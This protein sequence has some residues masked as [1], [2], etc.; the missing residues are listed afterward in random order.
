MPEKYQKRIFE[1]GPEKTTNQLCN[2]IYHRNLVCTKAK[3][4]EQIWRYS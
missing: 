1:S 3:K 2:S 4:I